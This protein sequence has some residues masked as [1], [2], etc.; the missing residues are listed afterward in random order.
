MQ[1]ATAFRLKSRPGPCRRPV[2]MHFP[3]RP[4]P[5]QNRHD[6]SGDCESFGRASFMGDPLATGMYAGTHREARI[7]R[8]S[9]LG[10]NA[11]ALAASL[12]S[13]NQ[14]ASIVWQ[15]LSRLSPPLTS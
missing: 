8:R 14:A 10:G 7:T 12:A 5:L 1:T 15:S 2:P 3:Q 4:F 9:C 11:D 13:E 6:A